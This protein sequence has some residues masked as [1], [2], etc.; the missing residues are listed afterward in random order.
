IENDPALERRFQ[1]VRVDEPTIEQT[2]EILHGV[3]QPY[4]DHHNLEITDEAINAAA[5]L[6][7]RYVTDRFL[8]DKAI[9]LIDE[10]ASRV[11]MYKSRE[12]T[13]FRHT[14]REVENL[15]EE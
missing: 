14:E 15:Q 8:P 1:K 6:S 10:G 11:R 9:D 4:E 5:N 13:S 7:A 12:S 3:K 2:I